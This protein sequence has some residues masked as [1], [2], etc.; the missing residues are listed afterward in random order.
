MSALETLILAALIATVWVNLYL[1]ADRVVEDARSRPA[2]PRPASRL[3][4]VRVRAKEPR[5]RR[6]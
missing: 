6:S 4:R 5:D 2:R 3:R 1:S